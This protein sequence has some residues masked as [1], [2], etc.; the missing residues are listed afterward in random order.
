MTRAEDV[1]STTAPY[2]SSARAQLHALRRRQDTA[3]SLL[4]RTLAHLAKVNPGLNAVVPL[5]IAAPTSPGP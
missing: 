3:R 5:D 1:M 4:D 2:R